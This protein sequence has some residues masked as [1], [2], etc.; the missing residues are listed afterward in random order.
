MVR[1]VRARDVRLILAVAAWSRTRS[2]RRTSPRLLAA[3]VSAVAQAVDRAALA[4]ATARR[5][6]PVCERADWSCYVRAG[7]R[8]C[9]GAL[10]AGTATVGG[11][12]AR[13]DCT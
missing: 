13:P 2:A 3:R 7:G 1:T 6:G 11:V 10:A 8:R 9:R 4:R 5:G 12:S